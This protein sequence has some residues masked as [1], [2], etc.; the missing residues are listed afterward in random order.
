MG[1]LHVNIGTRAIDGGG[2][3]VHIRPCREEIAGALSWLNFATTA[4]GI[5]VHLVGE[6]QPHR[7]TL[8][9]EIGL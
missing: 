4:R 2:S 9:Q 7:N 8:A 1:P 3:G 5:A 6:A